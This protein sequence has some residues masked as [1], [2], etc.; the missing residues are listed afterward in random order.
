[1]NQFIWGDLQKSLDDNETIEQAIARMIGEHEADPQAHQGEG[2]SLQNHKAS[3]IIDHPA[4]S[5]KIDKNTFYSFV[6]S[7][8]FSDFSTWSKS[9][10]FSSYS[11]GSVVFQ[12][13]TGSGN[14]YLKQQLDSQHVQMNDTF[15]KKFAVQAMFGSSSWNANS[16]FRMGIG[17]SSFNDSYFCGFQIEGNKLFCVSAKTDDTLYKYEIPNLDP[18]DSLMHGFIFL[19]DATLK[20]MSWYIDG[21]LVHVASS[22]L[23]SLTTYFD[24][25]VTFSAY[26][27][28][29]GTYEPEF[30]FFNP[31]FSVDYT[32]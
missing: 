18:I 6:Y 31:I 23:F 9:A 20:E 11:V 27:S 15:S 10:G 14:Y 28:S 4:G 19:Y 29:L 3:E 2:E 32:Y 5:V 22:D 7:L 16:K 17:A 12:S 25:H 8:L 26:L 30:Y 24:P 13:A 21:E 1:M